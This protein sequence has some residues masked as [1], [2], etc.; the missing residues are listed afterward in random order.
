MC[1]VDALHKAGNAPALAFKGGSVANV[2][3]GRRGAALRL[4]RWWGSELRCR[5][6]PI[7]HGPLAESRA[8]R[9]SQ[10]KGRKDKPCYRKN[11]S[12]LPGHNFFLVARVLLRI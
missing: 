12:P 10:P 9:Y 3:T 4:G 11:G 7:N 5:Y 2:D 1:R 6:I 8:H